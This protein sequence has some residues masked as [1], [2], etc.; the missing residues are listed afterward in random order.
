MDKRI[1]RP[2]KYASDEERR[3]ADAERKRLARERARELLVDPSLPVRDVGVE[4]EPVLEP[5]RS[6]LTVFPMPDFE[7]YVAD[8]VFMAE[9]HHSQTSPQARDSTKT[10]A[11]ALERAES[12]ARWRYAGVLSGEVNGL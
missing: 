6:S 5:K 12:Y 3:A 1:G 7:S 8:A 2:P 9:L 11:G 4:L 10:L